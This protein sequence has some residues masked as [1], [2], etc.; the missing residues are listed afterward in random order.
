MRPSL[1]K[2]LPTALLTL[3]LV[4]PPVAAPQAVLPTGFVDRPIASGLKFPVAMAPLPDGRVLFTEKGTQEVR[5]IVNSVLVAAPVG[6]V[7]NVRDTGGERGLLGIAVDPLFPARPYVY[8]HCD[9]TAPNY[10][11]RISRYTVTGDLS[12]TGNGALSIDVA[13]RRDLINQLPD[14]KEAFPWI[15]E[16]DSHAL[17]ASILNLNKAFQYF[18]A[19]AGFPRFKK[20]SG[21]QSVRFPDHK[22]EVNFEKG[23]ITLPKIPRIKASIDRA[24]RGKIRTVTVS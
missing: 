19:G 16:V 2:T 24:F 9:E 5:L 23:W 7:D 17:Q 13:T 15:A 10:T 21:W 1:R 6:T 18:F 8:V 11:I 22:R 12:F 20:K 14:L 3:A 4:S